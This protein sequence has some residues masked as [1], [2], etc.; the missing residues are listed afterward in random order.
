MERCRARKTVAKAP[1]PSGDSRSKSSTCCPAAKVR[2]RLGRDQQRGLGGGVDLKQPLQLVGTGGK[3]AT[4]VGNRHLVAVLPANV[5]LLVDQIAGHAAIDRQF[6]KLS[7]VLLDL[8]GQLGVPASD[9][10]G[11]P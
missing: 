2:Q 7:Q 6:R 11:R 9:I 8:F 1:L 10:R 3:A 4:V 5:I